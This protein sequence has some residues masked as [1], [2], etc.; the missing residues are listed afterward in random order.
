MYGVFN[1]FGRGNMDIKTKYYFNHPLF[2]KPL[3]NYPDLL[4][5]TNARALPTTYIRENVHMNWRTWQTPLFHQVHRCVYRYRTRRPR[6]L[7]WD[8]TMSQPAMPYVHDT[9]SKVING[10]WKFHTNTSPRLH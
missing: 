8:G 2:F 10:T 7:P 4:W 5:W 3:L 9:G 6:Y 1:L